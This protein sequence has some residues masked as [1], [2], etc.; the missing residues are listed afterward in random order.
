MRASD[1]EEATAKAA[2]VCFISAHP[3]YVPCFILILTP[4]HCTRK[5]F[6]LPPFSYGGWVRNKN[7]IPLCYLQ[8]CCHFHS[9]LNHKADSLF[10]GIIPGDLTAR[11]FLFL[12]HLPL[13]FQRFPCH[14]R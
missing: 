7:Y 3:Q 8:G 14:L 4:R 10:S 1:R 6:V 5:V 13:I 12:L 2:G 9:L 11:T